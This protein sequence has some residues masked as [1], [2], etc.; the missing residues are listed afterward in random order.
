MQTSTRLTARSSLRAI[1]RGQSPRRWRPPSMRS[2]S[3]W[4]GAPPLPILGSARS[5]AK[6][7]TGA[8]PGSCLTLPSPTCAVG[9]RRRPAPRQRIGHGPAA[10]AG[11]PLALALE[12]RAPVRLFGGP[13]IRRV[14]RWQTAREP[15][16]SPA[17]HEAGESGRTH[18]QAR[19]SGLVE[20]APRGL[21]SGPRPLRF[22]ARSGGRATAGR[23]PS[24][25]AR[26][27]VVVAVG[28]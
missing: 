4:K 7:S 10:R 11:L 20:A 15:C 6:R 1:S 19:A 23:R 26:R 14:C 5:A 12:R 9:S 17:R 18:G 24:Q 22:G 21:S 16:R 28:G 25:E 2:A 13:R 3:T 27:A 8:F